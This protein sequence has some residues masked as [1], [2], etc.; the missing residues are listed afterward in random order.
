MSVV[1]VFSS[2]KISLVSIADLFL[3]VMACQIFAGSFISTK[4]I[5][6]IPNLC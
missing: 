3:T 2:V 4:Q 1:C 5:E 6:Y